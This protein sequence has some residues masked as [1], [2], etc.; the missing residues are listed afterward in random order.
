MAKWLQMRHINA[1]AYWSALETEQRKE[2]EQQ[3]LDNEIKALVAT[4]ALGMG[5]D[6][7]DIGFVIHFQRPGSAIHYYQQVGRAGRAVQ[8]AFG[9]LLCGAEDDE[10]TDYFIRSAMPSV[11]HVGQVLDALKRASLGLN[12]SE[13]ETQ[14]NIR[15]SEID[16]VLS[17]LAVESPAPIVK[18]D[19]RWHLQEVKYCYDTLRAAQ[20]L[21]TKRAEQTR[22][23]EYM[24]TQ[25]CLMAFLKREL[26]D[27]DTR[28][29]GRCANCIGQPLL[30]ESCSETLVTEALRFLQHCHRRI[31]PRKR[32]PIGA[33]V[34]HDFRGS[35]SATLNMEEG[36]ALCR[37]GDAG[38]GEKVRRGKQ[39]DCH[40]DDELVNASFDLIRISWQ[41]RPFPKWVTC[42]PSL[43]NRTLVPDFAQRLARELRLPFVP[44]IV[45][46]HPTEAQKLRSNSFQQA[47]N[48][49]G[50]F[51][52]DDTLVKHEPVLLVDDMV[53]SRWTM[54]VVAALLRQAGSGPV[55]PFAL[56]VTTSE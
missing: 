31:E 36:R 42:V 11:E 34:E 29:C 15:R 27:P 39:Q 43:N 41:P 33:F 48:L 9:I 47:R 5:F 3:L 22:M 4:S 28:P 30:S 37:W 54:T 16:K 23:R 19:T 50:A 8:L 55:F 53:D 25:E 18:I 7:P 1:H 17:L 51:A 40:F 14:V 13:I 44:C 20:L 32:W 2:L 24:H 49:D 45:K 38:W 52:I 6:K 46:A 26:D 10:I 35:I 56:A 21:Q 12:I